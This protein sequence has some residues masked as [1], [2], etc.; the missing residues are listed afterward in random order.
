MTKQSGHRWCLLLLI[1]ALTCTGCQGNPDMTQGHPLAWTLMLLCVLLGV[2]VTV[3]PV[4]RRKRPKRRQ[5][6]D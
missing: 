3:A 5:D 6:D 4:N 1:S 2:A